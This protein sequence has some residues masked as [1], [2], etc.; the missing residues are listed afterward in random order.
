MRPTPAALAF[1]VVSALPVASAAQVR[2]RDGAA[3]GLWDVPQEPQHVGGP[4]PV[5]A[6][7]E[8][9]RQGT[10]IAT[11]AVLFTAA[12]VP[13]AVGALVSSTPLGSEP[14]WHDSRHLW[15]IPVAGPVLSILAHDAAARDLVPMPCMPSPPSP[16]MRDVC[17]PALAGVGSWLFAGLLASAQVYGLVLTTLGLIGSPVL[18]GPERAAAP[19]P[20]WRL[21]PGA[22]GAAAGA[23]LTAV[24]F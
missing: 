12:Y 20:Q 7:I 9:R 22:P 16:G 14:E 19:R 24:Y 8:T 17:D 6:R 5:G 13:F 3:D 10:L 23:T 1:V 4:V 18:V 2:A 11:G 15:L 21:A